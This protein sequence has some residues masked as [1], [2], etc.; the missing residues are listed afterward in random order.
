M[1]NV[2][3]LALRRREKIAT[4]VAARQQ[5][6]ASARG[7]GSEPYVVYVPDLELYW[8]RL[9]AEGAATIADD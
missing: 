5:R 4:D 1:H 7:S 2:E 9:S 3:R 6:L 8:K